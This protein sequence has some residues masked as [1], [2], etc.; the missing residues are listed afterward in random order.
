MQARTS[1]NNENLTNNIS[2]RL[3]FGNAHLIE[4]KESHIITNQEK[5][6]DQETII[7]FNE[8]QDKKPFIQLHDEAEDLD[9]AKW[10]S[11]PSNSRMMKNNSVKDS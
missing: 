2:P 9:I 5:T 6:H 7:S 1:Q 11:V 10:N 8:T 4:K 3:S